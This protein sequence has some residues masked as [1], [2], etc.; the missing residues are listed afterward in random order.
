MMNIAVASPKH[1]R[2]KKG[3]F[4]GA[5]HSSQKFECINT[6]CWVINEDCKKIV[7]QK[8]STHEQFF[9]GLYDISLAG[10]VDEQ[11]EPTEALIREAKEESGIDIKKSQLIR[12]GKIIFTEIGNYAGHS[13]R[14]NQQAYVHYLFLDN[15]Q[16]N[17]LKP[18][19]SEVDSFHSVSIDNFISMVYSRDKSLAPHPI[20]YYNFAIKE[21]AKISKKIAEND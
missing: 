15:N 5:A 19:S 1:R 2:L 18:N 14:H 4:I 3:V 9:S 11:E 12:S 17:K 13:F 21:L 6:H 8:R 10:H 20:K 7:L 16:I